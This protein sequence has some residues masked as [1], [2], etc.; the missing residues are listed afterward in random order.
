MLEEAASL[1]DRAVRAM[2]AWLEGR[3]ELWPFYRAWRDGFEEDP[4]G[5]TAFRSV[6]GRTPEEANGEWLGWVR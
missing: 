6:V 2:M 3:G 5:R 4:T 1:L